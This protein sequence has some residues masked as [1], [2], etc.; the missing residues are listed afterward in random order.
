M[1][2]KHHTYLNSGRSTSLT[3]TGTGFL[4]SNTKGRTTVGSNCE[5][6]QT[7]SEC[8]MK[9]EESID[10]NKNENEVK[11]VILTLKCAGEVCPPFKPLSE[12]ISRK[13]TAVEEHRTSLLS[14]K[15]SEIMKLRAET[16]KKSEDLERA[17]RNVADLKKDSRR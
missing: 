15:E 5:R 4:S 1:E 11:P 16:V 3:G 14:K 17:E 13:L 8:F 9:I 6:C 7:Y 10:N 2:E 12:A